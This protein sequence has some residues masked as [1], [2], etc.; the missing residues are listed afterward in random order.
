MCPRK[1]VFDK[2]SDFKRDFTPFL[3]DF[4][5]KPVLTSINNPQSNAPVERLHQ[6]IINMLVTKNIYN[7]VFDYIYPWGETIASIAWTIRASYRNTIM[8]K[9]VQAVFGRDMLFNRASVVY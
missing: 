6:V 3:K 1:V 7:K 8:S 5:I 9:P 4:D 2:S